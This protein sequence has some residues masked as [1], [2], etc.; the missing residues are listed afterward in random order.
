[1]ETPSRSTTWTGARA[2]FMASPRTETFGTRRADGARE[3][4]P[5]Q[6]PDWQISHPL[7]QSEILPAR[8][9]TEKFFKTEEG[10]ARAGR[11]AAAAAH[12]AAKGSATLPCRR[13]QSTSRPLAAAAGAQAS[14]EG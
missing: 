7:R 8:I 9:A 5:P 2:G 11:V 10:P 1:M 12:H 14:R 13:A 4:I 6:I 3:A